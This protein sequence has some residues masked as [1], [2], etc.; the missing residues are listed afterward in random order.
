MIDNSTKCTLAK[1]KYDESKG[2]FVTKTWRQVLDVGHQ[3]IS[4]ETSVTNIDLASR[5]PADVIANL[6]TDMDTI[7]S[8]SGTDQERIRDMYLDFIHSGR[9][10]LNSRIIWPIFLLDDFRIQ[11]R[12]CLPFYSSC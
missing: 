4:S 5:D 11:K 9:Y 12:C 8:K 1:E 10:C 6:K 2:M 7:C 3:H